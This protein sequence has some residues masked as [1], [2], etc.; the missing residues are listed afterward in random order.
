MEEVIVVPPVVETPV[1]E[2][3]T[4]P[5][6]DPDPVTPPAPVIEESPVEKPVVEEPKVDPEPD[7]KVEL[8]AY[9]AKM[10]S[11]VKD[12][13][14]ELATLKA[15]RDQAKLE[16]QLIVAGVKD[17]E[18]DVVSILVSNNAP[19]DVKK[20]LA[21]LKN[22]KPYLFMVAETTTRSG[23]RVVVT[24]VPLTPAD[25]AVRYKDL[26]NGK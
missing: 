12:L 17:T 2:A 26:I 9:K 7:P 18:V 6:A 15:E 23:E 3:V 20:Y 11:K 8:E 4:P 1:T 16:N 10:E 5:V 14:D 19:A 21:G 13:K 25:K 22:E 24:G